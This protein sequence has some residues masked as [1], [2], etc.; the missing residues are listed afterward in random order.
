VKAKKARPESGP[1]FSPY[2]S[3]I[4]TAETVEDEPPRTPPP[5]LTHSDTCLVCNRFREFLRRQQELFL[6]SQPPIR[7][8]SNEND[9][10]ATEAETLIFPRSLNLQSDTVDG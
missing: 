1:L 10:F 4:T 2:Y 3:E 6:L 5:L 9:M 8:P 7:V